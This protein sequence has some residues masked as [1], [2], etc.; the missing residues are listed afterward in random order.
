MGETR[1]LL[2][3]LASAGLLLGALPAEAFSSRGYWVPRTRSLSFNEI[4]YDLQIQQSPEK[5]K[6]N[7]NA[8]AVGVEGGI[9]E[10][11]KIFVEAGVDWLEPT[12]DDLLYGV[13]GNAKVTYQKLSVDGWAVSVGAEGFAVREGQHDDDLVYTVAEAEISSDWV[14]AMGGYAGREA[15]L[16]TSSGVLAGLWHKLQMGYGDVGVEWM[17]GQGKLGYIF[18]GVRAQVRDGFEA[19]L[20]YGIAGDREL[21]R[22]SFLARMT[23]YF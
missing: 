9:V 11:D 8:T 23:V 22:D 18:P 17:S 20:A 10:Y 19:V 13:V 5:G 14:A 4:K 12:E 3:I 1:K 7:Q 21:Y 2:L 6:P 15:R 16:K